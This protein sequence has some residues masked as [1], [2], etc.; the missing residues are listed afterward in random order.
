MEKVYY[1][2]IRKERFMK[3]K[4]TDQKQKGIWR[5]TLVVLIATGLMAGLMGCKD[6]GNESG[7]Q[8]TNGKEQE[9]VQTEGNYYS[10]EYTPIPEEG[11]MNAATVSG[12]TVF[13]T[14]YDEEKGSLLRK[15]DTEEKKVTDVS[16]EKSES[17]SIELLAVNSVGNLI[18][19]KADWSSADGNVPYTLLEL[20]DDGSV[21][22]EKELN[23]VFSGSMDIP[24]FYYLAVGKEDRICLSNGNTIWILDKEGNVLFQI[25]ADSFIT[26]MGTLPDGS[27]AVSAYEGNKMVIKLIDF[28]KKDWGASFSNEKMTS[29]EDIRFAEGGKEGE[30][31]LYN[32]TALY[33]YHMETDTV[34]TIANWLTNDVLYDNL[35][36]VS[37][38]E[39]GNIQMVSCNS[40][41]DAGCELAM[42]TKMDTKEAAKKQIITLGTVNMSMDLRQS[43]IQFNRTNKKYRIEVITYG[44]SSL[45]E[46]NETADEEGTTRMKNEIVAGN[47]PDLVNIPDGSEGFYASKGLLEDLKPY[48]D[49]ENGLNRADYFENILEAME[50]DGKLYV[51]TPDFTIDTII[52]KTSEVGDG[53]RWTMD[54]LIRLAQER[55]KGVEVFDHET[56]QQA[57]HCCLYYNM[58]QFFDLEEGRCDFDNEEFKKVLEFANLFP[59]V[60]ERTD[61]DKSQALSISEGRILLCEASL[62]RAR[63]YQ[64]YH[65][66]FG[67]DI[68]FVGYPTKYA[69]G[70]AAS[71]GNIG[72]AMNA[73][74]E[75][76]EGAWE[77][78]RF[79]MGEEYQNNYTSWFPMMKSAFEKNMEEEM[80]KQYATDENGEQTEVSTIMVG[81]Q[82]Y[83]MELYAATEEE[84]SAIRTLIGEIDHM[85][86]SDEQIYNIVTEEAAAYFGGQKSVDEVVEVI[87]NRANIYMNES[88]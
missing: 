55:E 44:S 53:S 21:I 43:V 49:G 85:V 11:W 59:E 26:A 79:L 30:L 87:Q 32:S 33:L 39:N 27:V 28:E 86:Q 64:M 1:K 80:K 83:T 75:N 74:S 73:E 84:V 15:Y 9:Q 70:S 10:G 81:W 51:L 6:R 78:I 25:E 58:E 61:T 23:E 34:E 65:N 2:K 62:C 52:G 67:Q 29:N 4:Q 35:V 37:V 8:S 36:F 60:N 77:F 20:E 63:D 24:Y 50:D 54:T 72:L 14:V 13:Y 3:K 66:M 82:D 7:G 38:L 71:C 46:E 47:M 19:V 76:K 22:M 17:E 31:Y 42:L 56:K 12:K 69:C 48:F 45:A 88:K 57:L 18:A 68:S 5:R 16:V 41:G 40:S